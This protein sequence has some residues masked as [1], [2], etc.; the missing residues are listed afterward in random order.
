[1]NSFVFLAAKGFFNGQYF[2]RLDTSI[3]VVQGGDPTGTGTGGPGYSIP[4]EYTGKEKYT[5]GTFAM[6]HAQA[7][8]SGGSQFFLITGEEG[9]TLPSQ[10]TIFGH[11][12]NGLGVSTKIQQL[13]IKDPQ[14]AAGD[15]AAQASRR[16]AIYMDK[17]TVSVR[18]SEFR[19][20][21]RCGASMPLRDAPRVEHQRAAARP[22]RGVDARVRREDHD[23]VL[24]GERVLVE[25]HRAELLPAELDRPGRTG[26]GRRRSAPFF[27]SRSRTPSD[28]DSR[29]SSTPGLNAT[30]TPRIVEPRAALPASFSASAD[31]GAT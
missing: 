6:A 18:R 22:T 16:Q 30:P 29:R 13:P 11:V 2:T 1:M 3:D 20:G 10:Y 14:G 23:A 5:P 15:I 4:D 19:G 7:A 17:V 28:G 21:R 25:R 9:A 8:N 31:A 24:R 27:A 12:T 26:R